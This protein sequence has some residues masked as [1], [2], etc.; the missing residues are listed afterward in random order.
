MSKGE[1]GSFYGKKGKRAETVEGGGGVG[2]RGNTRK[3]DAPTEGCNKKAFE[4]QLGGEINPKKLDRS[5]L[6]G[7]RGEEERTKNLRTQPERGNGI[8]WQGISNEDSERDNP[9]I[10][11]RRHGRP[12]KRGLQFGK[13][14]P[15]PNKRR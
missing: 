4:I 9:N 7:A 3:V 8:C 5:P 12:K 11:G 13:S 6:P 1:G 2:G 14:S 15:A 10:V